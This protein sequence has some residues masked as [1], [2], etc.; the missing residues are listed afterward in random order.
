MR[1]LLIPILLIACLSSCKVNEQARDL[2][3]VT[4]TATHESDPGSKTTLSESHVL[5]S[6]GDAISIFSTSCTTGEQYLINDEDAGTGQARFTGNSVGAAPYYALYPAGGGAVLEGS[7]IRFS[8]PAVQPY[9]A[10]GFASGFNPMIASSSDLSLHF[11]N[12]CALLTVRL[13]GSG[14]VTSVSITSNKAESL[15]GTASVGLNYTDAPTLVMTDTADD[16]HRTVVLDCGAGVALGTDPVEFSLVVPAGSLSEGFTL[17]VTDDAQGSMTRSTS[18]PISLRRSVCSRMSPIPYVLTDSPFL[19]QSVYGV[20][21]ID[22]SGPVP[23]KTYVK[24]TDQLALR[25]RLDSR[26]FRIQSLQTRSAL[27]VTFPT[28][29]EV[30]GSYPLTVESVGSTGVADASVTATLLKSEGGRLWLQETSGNR[31]FII[32]GDL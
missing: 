7:A 17:K 24:G 15:W 21:T 9:A 14:T 19:N 13:T 32:A 25:Y 31:G 29:M 20:Y 6:A 30:G 23:V 5:W 2:P 10:S 12:L 11:R 8:L 1:K 26:T 16:A 3:R 4:F 28:E 22:G 27:L 18:T